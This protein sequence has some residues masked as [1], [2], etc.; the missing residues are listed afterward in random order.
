MTEISAQ[1]QTDPILLLESLADLN[2]W[3]YNRDSVSDVSSVKIPGEY[4]Q[5]VV[6]VRWLDKSEMLL[7]RVTI[8]VHPIPDYMVYEL[9]R[10]LNLINTSA[11]YGSW[12]IDFSGENSHHFVWRQEIHSDV[13][14]IT[15]ER[16]A[17]L[18]THCC[19]ACDN[20]YPAFQS[21]LTAKPRFRGSGP[22]AY[23]VALGLDAEEAM[24]YVDDLRPIGTA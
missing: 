9:C 18:L 8:P 21:F 14:S 5:Y 15:E 10:L 12:F 20:F 19:L 7:V 17:R 3:N 6:C 2:E 1:V 16:M 11:V 22:D 13:E 24:E 23:L 4:S